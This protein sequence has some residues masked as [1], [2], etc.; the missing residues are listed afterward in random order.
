MIIVNYFLG[1]EAGVYAVVLRYSQIILFVSFSLMTVFIPNLSSA[2]YSKGEFHQKVQQYFLLLLGMQVLLMGAYYAVFPFT[3][4]YLFGTDYI[5]AS[6][7][8]TRGA[9]M[10]V[11]LVNS[12]FMVNVNIILERGKYLILLFIGALSLTLLLFRFSFGIVQVLD[13]GIGVYTVL[14]ATLGLL[15]LIERRNVYEQ[16]A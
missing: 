10:Y 7:Y 1:R 15:Y 4:K 3:V 9:F 8:L 14:F 11:M 16:V 6:R 13:I 2:R 5:G 12:F